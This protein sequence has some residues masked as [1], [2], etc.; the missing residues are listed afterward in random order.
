MMITAPVILLLDYWL[1]LT[2]PTKDE[3]GKE[4][5]N[6]ASSSQD[7]E[8]AATQRVTYREKFSQLPPLIFT[9][10][11]PL[12]VTVMFMLFINQGLFELIV[13]PHMNLGHNIQYRLYIALSHLGILIGQ[14]TA[15]CFQVKRLWILMIMEGL[16]VA[17]FFAEVLKSFRSFIPVVI[18]A[19]SEGFICGCVFANAFYRISGDGKSEA[20]TD[21]NLEIAMLF[22]EAGAATAGF[23]SIPAHNFICSELK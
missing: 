2:S 18:G 12:F 20:L 9:V 13:E 14:S 8:A 3:D 5:N 4:E 16:L 21:F 19:V 11:L 10:M 17:F 1:L 6:S 7:E 15:Q 23:L 22:N